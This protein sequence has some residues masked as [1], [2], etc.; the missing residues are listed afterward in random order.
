MIRVREIEWGEK[1]HFTPEVTDRPGWDMTAETAC[2][3]YR[4]GWTER[5]LYGGPSEYFELHGPDKM[6]VTVETEAAGRAL[7]QSDFER[8][9]RGAI[10]ES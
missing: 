6:R 5:T 7:A 10:I 2:G 1:V 9:I 4:I 3:S 8:R